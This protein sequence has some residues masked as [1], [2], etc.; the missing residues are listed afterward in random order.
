MLCTD[1]SHLKGK[2]VGI[3]S[4]VYWCAVSPK[5]K[6]GKQL[7]IKPWMKKP[8]PKCPLKIQKEPPK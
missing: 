5:D 3:V 8:H 6:S 4:S 2:R 7:G 1:C